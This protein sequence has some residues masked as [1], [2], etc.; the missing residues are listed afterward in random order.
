MYGG[1]ADRRRGLDWL[2]TA[3]PTV[4]AAMLALSTVA[5]AQPAG[6]AADRRIERILKRTPL[7]DGHNDLPWEIRETYDSWRKPLDLAADTSGLPAPLQ[8]DLPRLKA[9]GVGAQFWSVW[10]P[11]AT[12]GAEAVRTTLE[13]I[14]I[15]H[16]MV[17]R[18]P[19]RLEMASTAADIGRIHRA[20]RIAS[21][22]G[23]EGG[24]QIA[25]SPAILR[26]YH[27]L[28]ARYM[29][30]THS[31]NN[32]WADS[33]TDDPKHGGLTAFGKAL[34]G[35]MNRIGMMIDLSH[36]SP[37]VMKQAIALSKSP[38]IF[39]HSNARAVMDHGRNVPDDVLR[40][41]PANGGVV[42]V[43]FYPGFLSLPYR[44]RMAGRDAEEARVKSLYSGQ[45]ERRAAA[46][47]AW[48]AAHPAAPATL[49]QVA[50]HIDHIRTV[51][52][53]DHVGIGSD[54]DGISGTSPQGLEGADRYPALLRELIRRGW[55]D[56][57]LAKL[58]GGNLLRAMAHGER[59]AASMR[60]VPP[61]I[62]TIA[63]LD[64]VKP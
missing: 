62:A 8:T 25:N 64:G 44:A 26:Q 9:G 45:P 27:A 52:G 49:A 43:N 53:A 41:L 59:V 6:D 32:D 18:Y 50:D 7:I 54:F 14:E 24:H 5:S 29:T 33:G 55:S 13:Q 56:E 17:A 4:L 19:D 38:V 10:I 3:G 21:L 40:L 36:V 60:G 48:D 1:K 15:V 12:T 20:G 22:I 63:Q 61:M 58:A 34:L 46:M 11:G 16:R 51:A 47:A 23:V 2:R 31:A 42:M 57:D 37:D 28:G 39:S 30:L 35:E